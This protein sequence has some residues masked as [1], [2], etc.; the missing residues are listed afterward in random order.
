MADVGESDFN[1]VPHVGEAGFYPVPHAGESGLDLVPPASY[2]GLDLCDIFLD[3]RD[4]RLESGDTP[5]HLNL[6][7]V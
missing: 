4:V 2:I 6:F 1:L 5:F 7:V 3:V